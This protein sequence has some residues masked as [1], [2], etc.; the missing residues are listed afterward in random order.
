MQCCSPPSRLAGLV[1]EVRR[2]VPP[3]GRMPEIASMSTS[4]VLF[5]KTPRQPSM[6]PTN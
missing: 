6:K 2:M 3:R 5:S 1:R 4:M